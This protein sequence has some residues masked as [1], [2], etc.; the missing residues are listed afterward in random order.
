MRGRF[1]WTALALTV[2]L[3]GCAPS[4]PL[5]LQRVTEEVGTFDPQQQADFLRKKSSADRVGDV[6]GLD[7]ADPVV[8]QWYS[9]VVGLQGTGS[10]EIP[11]LPAGTLGPDTTLKNELLKS[12]YWSKVPGSPMEIL[13]SKDTAPVVVGA[14]IPPL[15]RLNDRLDVEV[16]ALGG[17]TSLQG[18]VLMYTPLRQLLARRG[19]GTQYGDVW[20]YAEGKLSLS[21]GRMAF[22]GARPEEAMRG[23]VPAG[24]VSAGTGFLQLRLRRPDAYTASLLLLA[25]N[26]RF[27]G[28]PALLTPQ[29][30]RITVPNYYYGEW[31]RL[32]Q[33]LLEVRCRPPRGRFLSGYINGLVRNLTGNDRALA[34]QASYRLEALG[35]ESVPALEGALHNPQQRTQLLAARTLAAMREPAGIT[36]LMQTI[37]LGSDADRRLAAR[38]L[39]FYSQ[40]N[41]RDYQ[42]KLLVDRDPEVRYRALLGLEQTQED[43]AYSTREQAKGEDFS[44]TRVQCAGT[45]ALLVKGRAPRRLVFFGPDLTFRPPF[46]QEQTKQLQVEA[47][48]SSGVLVTYLVYGQPQQLSVNSMQ[49]VDLV[50]ALDHINLPVTDI[51]DLI[52]RLSRADTISGEVVFLDE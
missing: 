40:Y 17:A 24:A 28:C 4:R 11:E 10:G 21:S 13:R 47:K 43:T 19:G 38:Y 32:G 46:K 37:E 16:Q 5:T 27:P 30:V 35:P 50:R 34:E 25:I 12:L 1:S 8:V 26:D 23:F 3:A 9:L 44:I 7:G 51:M 18:G 6:A 52:F 29:V 49:V 15:V 36:P 31:Q 20:A 22:G 41:V 42:K 45:A 14:V 2:V 48:D 39:N 33:V